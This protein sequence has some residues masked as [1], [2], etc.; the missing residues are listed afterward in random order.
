M[1]VAID[2]AVIGCGQRF[3]IG[4]GPSLFLGGALLRI[5]QGIPVVVGPYF[6]SY[7]GLFVF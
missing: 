2:L 4:E 7:S 1:R 3:G 5:F 6:S